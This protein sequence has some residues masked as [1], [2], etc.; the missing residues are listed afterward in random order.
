MDT[1][2]DLHT[3]ESEELVENHEEQDLFLEDSVQSTPNADC[4]S[5][6]TFIEE[7]IENTQLS[8]VP[9]LTDC[10]TIVSQEINLPILVES[11]DVSLDE[12]SEESDTCDGGN[13]ED[14]VGR[15]ACLI[16]DREVKN[17]KMYKNRQL[18]DLRPWSQIE[19]LLRNLEIEN[20]KN[21]LRRTLKDN[22]KYDLDKIDDLI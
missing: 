22:D 2:E 19:N 12:S 14:L 17:H 16:T 8:N 20:F 1:R 13:F 6:S 10:A 15:R 21:I 11:D 4:S 5:T 7:L 9:C 3:S 18:E